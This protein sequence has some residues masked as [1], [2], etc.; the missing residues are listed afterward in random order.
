MLDKS[1]IPH[2]YTQPYITSLHKKP[3]RDVQSNPFILPPLRISTQAHTSELQSRKH[4]RHP[5]PMCS[6]LHFYTLQK[7]VPVII[8]RVQIHARGVGCS[9]PTS[10]TTLS[11]RTAY[12]Y[13]MHKDYG[14]IEN[15]A[16]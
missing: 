14:S 16:I 11:K 10:S 2:I 3:P 1:H 15:A 8:A 9:G 5:I 6:Y 7:Q 4:A 13:G 12:V